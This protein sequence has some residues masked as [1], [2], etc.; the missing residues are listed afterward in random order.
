M[1]SEVQVPLRLQPIK[2]LT[3]KRQF[4]YTQQKSQLNEREATN[5]EGT[6]NYYFINSVYFQ[7]YT[8]IRW[9]QMCA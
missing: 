1:R 3:D 2:Q 8:A 4:H 7:V 5:Y 6:M 9:N